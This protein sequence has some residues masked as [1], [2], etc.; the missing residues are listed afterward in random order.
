MR[1]ADDKYIVKLI[2]KKITD[3]PKCLSIL[4][5][6]AKPENAKKISLILSKMKIDENN[7]K[8]S[9]NEEQWGLISLGALGYIGSL[10]TVDFLLK[11]INTGK[12]E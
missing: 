4:K 11:I 3:I 10:N 9:V 12:C 8:S 6:V 7:L 1:T 2:D 5:G